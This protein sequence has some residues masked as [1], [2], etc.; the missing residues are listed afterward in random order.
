[1]PFQSCRSIWKQMR[2]ETKKG[3]SSSPAKRR[4]RLTERNHQK[5]ETSE[6]K[7]CVPEFPEEQVYES[8]V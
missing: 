4:H 3:Q 5:V 1:M 8:V 2:S 6:E 7:D